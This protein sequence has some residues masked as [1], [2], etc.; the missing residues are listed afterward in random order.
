VI[1]IPQ[2]LSHRQTYRGHP[3]PFRN[4]VSCCFSLV[5]YV[6][7][8]YKLLLD[9]LWK[10]ADFGFRQKHTPSA[11]L[12][13]ELPMSGDNSYSQEKRLTSRHKISVPVE[14]RAW[15]SDSPE[16]ALV[17]KVLR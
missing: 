2:H 11:H 16:R 15:K 10:T 14:F 17:C 9:P 12:L 3:V 1:A 8:T 13:W 6:R 4:Q 5:Q 7:S